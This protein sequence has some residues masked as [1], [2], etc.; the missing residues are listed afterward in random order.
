MIQMCYLSS[1][2]HP[3]STEQLLEL[4]K[5]CLD[6]NPASGVTGMLLYANGTFLQALEGDEKIVADLY[7]KIEKDGRHIDVKML[8]R[9]TIETRQYAEWSMGFRRVSDAEL[10]QVEGLRDFNERDF[11]P[12]YLA[13]HI[14]A[15][16]YIMDHYASWDPLVREVDEKERHVKHLQK[17]LQRATG[18]IEIARLVL[19]SVV[20]AHATRCFGDNHERLC[21]FA[22]A[23]LNQIW[24]AARPP[25]S[26]L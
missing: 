16:E 10:Q 13:E 9:R 6:F 17:A 11:N 25:V 15:R 4:L 21:T 3:M 8:H 24:V 23:Q 5:Q 2:A 26:T 12:E 19:E 14:A 7:S 20:D 22:L 18:G 1:A